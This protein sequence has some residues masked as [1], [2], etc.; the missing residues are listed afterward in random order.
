MACA[1]CKLWWCHVHAREAWHTSAGL[2]AHLTLILTASLLFQSLN[3]TPEVHHALHLWSAM[4]LAEIC[5]G[6]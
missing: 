1:G 4:L 3:R 6:V 5:R 2:D